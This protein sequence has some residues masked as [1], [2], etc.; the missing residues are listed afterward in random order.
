M[1]QMDQGFVDWLLESETPSIRYKTLRHLM[2]R[3]ESEPEVQRAKRAIM[4]TGPAPAI[5]YGQAPDGHWHHESSYYTPKYTSSHWSMM[6]LAELDADGRDSRL[7]AGA[8]SMLTRTQAGKKKDSV[9]GPSQGLGCFW[10]NMLRYTLHC[11]FSGDSRLH[12]VVRRLVREALTSEWGCKY[13]LA[14][15][16]AWGAARAL[17]GLAALPQ[18]QRTPEVEEAIESGLSFLLE[19]HSLVDADHPTSGKIH[20]LWFRLN[21]P[22]FYQAD[23]LFVLRVLAELGALRRPGAA[24]ALAW[25]RGRRKANGR[26]RGSSPYRQRTWP[27]LGDKEDADR[28]VSLQAVTILGAA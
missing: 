24:P 28:W 8:D 23:I 27:E 13:N 16:C 6:L 18:E 12:A 11:G 22:L 2:G 20:P 3:A 26:W 19:A 25:L 7:Q 17:W 10:G 14:L 1:P 21:F 4:N 9:A 5:L 15:P